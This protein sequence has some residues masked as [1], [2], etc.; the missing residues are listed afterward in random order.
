MPKELIEGLHTYF[1]HEGE[2]GDKSVVCVKWSRETGDIQ[3]A[4]RLRTAEVPGPDER[5]PIPAKY[6]WYVDLDRDT[7]NEVIRVLRRARTQVFG[8]DE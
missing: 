6:G 1:A 8:R 5:G 4:T 3:I 2:E 7:I